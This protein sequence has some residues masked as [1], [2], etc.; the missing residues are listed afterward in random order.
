[1]DDLEAIQRL[2]DGDIG[3]LEV[4]VTRYQDK[5]VR[6][7][8]LITHDEDESVDIVLCRILSCEFIAVST[9]LTCLDLSSHI[10]CEA[11]ST[12]R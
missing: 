12:P 3:G 8:F 4:L 7:A 1:M 2:K 9:N 5:A 6:T 10:C 11:W